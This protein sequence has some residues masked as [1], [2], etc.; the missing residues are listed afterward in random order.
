MCGIAGIVAFGN[1]PFAGGNA[2]QPM[3]AAMAKRGPDD[4]GFLVAVA[5]NQSPILAYG[6]A[7]CSINA[8]PNSYRPTVSINSLSEQPAFLWFAHRRLSIIDTSSAGH[9]PMSG[10]NGR[11]WIIYNGEIYNFIEIRKELQQKGIKFISHS[12]T[13]V[14]I[15][16]YVMWGKKLLPK[17]NGMFAFAIWDKL[18]NTIFFARDRIGIKP[19]YYTVI[20]NKL[21]FASDIKTIIA[22]GL[23]RPE[24]DE[25]GLYHALSYGVAPRPMTCFK[26]VQA[27]PPA[28]HLTLDI[29][30]GKMQQE[31]YWRLPVGTQQ[32]DMSLVYATEKLD[33]LLHT[34]VQ[35][36]LVA[37]VPIGSF[38]SGGIDSTTIT[39][40]AA[41][42][43]PDIVAFTLGYEGKECDYL[44]EVNEAKATA[45]LYGMQHVV[46][47]Q[48]AD[49]ILDHINEIVRAYEEPFFSLSPNFLISKLAADNGVKVAFSGLGGDELFAGYQTFR[50]AKH[51]RV[52]KLLM[53]FIKIASKALPKYKRALD[54]GYIKQL[55]DL[56]GA[57][58]NNMSSYEKDQLFIKP[59]VDNM[60]SFEKLRELYLPEGVEFSDYIEAMSYMYIMNYISNHHVYRVDQFTMRFSVEGR[61]PLLDHEL[62]EFVFKIP[63]HFKFHNGKQKF[64]LHELAKKY[65][66]SSSLS[67]AKKGFDLPMDYWIRF[68][69]WDYVVE[70]LQKLA[71][72]QVFNP[73]VITSIIKGFSNKRCDDYTLWSLVGTELWYEEFID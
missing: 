32:K 53:P 31:C 65:I 73:Q 41:Q 62:I 19:L 20:N 44:N 56:H 3:A 42:H 10:A 39:A 18:Q 70:K 6:E 49:C 63:S 47:M 5:A 71:D 50:W 59:P 16:A 69:L 43:K 22:S 24:V 21:V 54:F 38:M 13:E 40:I 48:R 46:S 8:I 45:E 11:Y 23:Y 64:V 68:Q 7:S 17:L 14:L 15:Q 58:M 28:C 1:E 51:W 2:I 4:E 36:R 52:L 9:Q 60:R 37:D 35:R 34:S 33:D 25:E 29:A 27:L 57:L 55:S 67:M 26:H 30:Q 72:R 66:D 12:D 61:F